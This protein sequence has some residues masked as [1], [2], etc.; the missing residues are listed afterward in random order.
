M[1]SAA[2]EIV[3]SILSLVIESQDDN[4]PTWASETHSR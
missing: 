3:L 1:S 2:H 4:L